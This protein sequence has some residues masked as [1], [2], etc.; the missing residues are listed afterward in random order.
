MPQGVKY[1]C[2][3]A[4]IG[5]AS[6]WRQRDDTVAPRWSN[7]GRS[8]ADGSRC[9]HAGARRRAGGVL[10][11]HRLERDGDLQWFDLQS[12][13]RRQYRLWRQ[14]AE[15]PDGQ[16]AIRRLG[17]RH[18]H[19]HRRQQQQHDQQSRHHH[20]SRQRRRR[21][22]VRHQRQ[23]AADREQFRQHRSRRRCQQHLRRG[24]HHRPAASS[25]ADSV[26]RGA[27]PARS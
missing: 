8:G 25:R 18:V 11:S 2:E 9:Y 10:S 3:S 14:H 24:G 22:R 15:R 26:S 21:R 27:A 13:S 7:V 19:W 4:S 20:H 6:S 1:E 5:A 16:R 12:G 23:W 17:D